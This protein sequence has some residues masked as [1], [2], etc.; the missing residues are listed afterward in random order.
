MGAIGA[1]IGKTLGGMAGSALGGIAGGL[2]PFKRGG[3]V[4]GPRGKPK[5]ILAHGGETVIP[6]GVKVTKAQ[7]QAI[8]KLHKKGKK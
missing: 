8:A 5:V 3:K 6:L 7:K 4:P 2:L 1:S